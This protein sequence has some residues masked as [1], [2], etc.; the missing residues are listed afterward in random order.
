MTHE[1]IKH[2]K[3]TIQDTDGNGYSAAVGEYLYGV[4]IGLFGKE[5]PFVPIVKVEAMTAEEL[6]EG[7]K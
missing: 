2:I 5:Y 1:D 4:I 6:K 3:V 7:L